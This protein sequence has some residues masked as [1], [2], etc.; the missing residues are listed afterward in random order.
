MV[1]GRCRLKY[2]DHRAAAGLGGAYEHAFASAL[3]RTDARPLPSPLNFDF[4]SFM[5]IS[6]P[7]L[8]C[9]PFIKTGGLADVAGCLPQAL[10]AQGH[11]V[12]VI[13][14]STRASARTGGAR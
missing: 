2:T 6:L 14:P 13:L 7:P 5:N 8:K 10:A 4:G 3:R 11:D 9:A 12:R 1:Q